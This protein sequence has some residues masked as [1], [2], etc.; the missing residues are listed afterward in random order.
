MNLRD[1]GRSQLPPL[2]SIDQWPMIRMLPMVCSSLIIIVN[3]LKISE[4]FMIYPR[5]RRQYSI[6]VNLHAIY[7][8]TVAAV[9]FLIVT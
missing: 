5:L 9:K 3:K 4:S 8:L 6:Q 2:A 1:H 7:L